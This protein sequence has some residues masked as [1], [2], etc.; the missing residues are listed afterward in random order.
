[1]GSFSRLLSRDADKRRF[2]SLL[3]WDIDPAVLDAYGLPAY[4][5]YQFREEPRLVRRLRKLASRP[6]RRRL[7]QSEDFLRIGSFRET[8]TYRFLA[9]LDAAAMDWR[10]TRRYGEYAARIAR[11]E[12][13]RLHSKRKH[14]AVEAD[15][16]D[17]F[18]EYVDLLTSMRERGYLAT[19]SKDRITVMIDRDGSLFK[20]TKG[21]HRLAAAMIARAKSVPVRISH[22]HA[23]W[24]EAQRAMSPQASREQHIE[25]AI[26]RAMERIAAVRSRDESGDAA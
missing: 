24:V 2:A 6:K 20:E 11:G 3:R 14:M 9:E 17:Y 25:A 8:E 13:V 1:M 15:L 16:D 21:R 4:K 19:G 23:A 12:A 7:L 18:R 5:R 22:V 26:L 10:R